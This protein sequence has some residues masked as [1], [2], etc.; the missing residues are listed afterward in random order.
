MIDYMKNPQSV[1]ETSS[2]GAI[3]EVTAIDLYDSF[4]ITLGRI[5]T[6]INNKK[7][8]EKIFEK[9]SLGK[10]ALVIVMI[11]ATFLLITIKPVIESDGGIAMLPFA[12]IFP[13]IG[14]SVLF[15][16]L[17]GKTPIPVKIFGLIWGLG[18]GGMP[19]AFMVLPSCSV[20]LI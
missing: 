1:P 19:W 4:Y 17:F 10:G 12:I 3:T 8:K 15:G 6:N 14:F 20:L 18:F 16:M 11:I 13:G 9:S 7:N 5:I 2:N